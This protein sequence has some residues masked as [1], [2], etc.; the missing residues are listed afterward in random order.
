MLITEDFKNRE[1]M[2]LFYFD[3]KHRGPIR[4]APL[5]L[6]QSKNI[7]IAFKLSNNLNDSNCR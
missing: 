5:V 2:C 6:T 1:F 3:L 7:L 4:G